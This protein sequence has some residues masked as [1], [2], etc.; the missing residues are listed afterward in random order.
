MTSARLPVQKAPRR[1][2][3]LAGFACYGLGLSVLYVKTGLGLI[4]PFR[5]VTGWE[6]PLCG[7]TRLGGALLHLELAAAFAFNPL[8]LVAL[9]VLSVLGVVWTLELLTRAALRPPERLARDGGKIKHLN[10][11]R[12]NR[13]NF[14]QK[15]PL[16]DLWQTNLQC[17]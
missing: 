1:L 15:P 6:C 17:L 11:S 4:C 5:L 14:I 12:S 2:A 8:V 16:K 3:F 9:G 13:L 7:A 10:G